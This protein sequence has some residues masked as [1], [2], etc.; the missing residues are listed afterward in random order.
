MS[1]NRLPLYVLIGG[2]LGILIG[3]INP[4]LTSILAPIGDIYVRLMEVIVLPYLI[5]SLVLGLGQ[6]APQTAMNLFRKSWLIYIALWVMTFVV[7]AF[8]ALTVPLVQKSAIVDFATT[9]SSEQQSGTALVDLLIPNNFFEALSNNYI[10]SIVLMG[11]IFGIAIQHSKK[12]TELLEVLSIIQKACVRIWGWVILMAPMGVCALFAGSI[13][14]MS[15][16]GFAAM[17]IYIIVIVL[18]ALLVGLWLLPMM[19]SAFVP[20]GYRELMS[21]LRQAMLIAVATSLS[22]AALPLIQAATLKMVKKYRA[23][24]KESEQSEVIQTTLS[25]SYPLAQIGNFF[26]FI[27]LLYA[28]S[29]YFIPLTGMQLAELPLVTLISGF[30][31]PSSSIG[32]VTFIAD[33]LKLPDGTTDLYVETMAITR[34]FQVVASVSAFAFVT[35]LVT[36][37]FYGGLRFDLRRFVL[38]VLVAA[39]GLSAILAVGRMGGTHIKFYSQTSYLAQGLPANVQ[40]LGDA[41]LPSNFASGDGDRQNAQNARADNVLDRVQSSG[42]LRVGVNPNVM[43]FAYKNQKGRLVGYDVELMYRFAHDMSVDLQFV[44]YDWHSLT[45]DLSSHKF[46]IAISG[47]YITRSRMES[48]TFSEPYYENPLALIV[49]TVRVADFASREKINAQTN[50]TIAVFDDPVLIETAKR[51]FPTATFKILENYDDLEQHRDVDAALWTLE[52]ARAWAIS[53]DGYSTA[54][55]KNIGTRFLF[56]YLM[57]PNADGIADYLNYWMG[58]QQENGVLKDMNARWIGQSPVD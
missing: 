9:L 26:I 21:E 42:V 19:L 35:I 30:G 8:A 23:S 25:V 58:L 3:L 55:P 51:S 20:M 13:S 57:P 28:S 49:P 15:P 48:Y 46:D 34:Y 53:H 12:P 56:A 50:L 17:S 7:L 39:I 36:F 6:L 38:T 31:A 27:F 18:T 40:A 47:L 5:S 43:P 2:L 11:L 33:W 24:D 22:V 14:T 41:N 32:A 37:A 1:V 29:Y 52:Q 16:E 4:F 10:P 44:P 54:V 45:A